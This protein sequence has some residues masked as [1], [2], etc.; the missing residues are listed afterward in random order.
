MSKFFYI[1]IILNLYLFY[2]IRPSPKKQ[3]NPQEFMKKIGWLQGDDEATPL[4]PS[5]P[6]K[7]RQ[8]DPNAKKT[9]SKG[10]QNTQS[11]YDYSKHK[12]SNYGLRKQDVKQK[13]KKEEIASSEPV[14]VPHYGRA[15]TR[16][17]SSKPA[18][19]S[20]VYTVKKK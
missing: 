4:I 5:N 8:H 13:S 6:K 2:F 19:R 20:K 11:S 3:E 10:T 14:S 16:V 18:Q 17:R 12:S 9:Q 15:S 1:I 7:G